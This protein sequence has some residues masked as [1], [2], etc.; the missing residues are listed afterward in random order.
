MGPKIHAKIHQNERTSTTDEGPRLESLLNDCKPLIK[1]RSHETR[2]CISGTK[3]FFPIC[4][5]FFWPALGSI[6]SGSEHP[7]MAEKLVYA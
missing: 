5:D 2:Q 6:Q 3:D 1:V 7:T 4:V